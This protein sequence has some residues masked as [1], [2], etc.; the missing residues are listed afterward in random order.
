M[1]DTAIKG[2]QTEAVAPKQPEPEPEEDNISL[3]PDSTEQTPVGEELTEGDTIVAGEG[4]NVLGETDLDEYKISDDTMSETKGTTGEASLEEIEESVNLDTFGSGSGLLDLSLQ[5]DDTSLGGILDEIYT[6]EGE[7]EAPA[8]EG[9]AMDVA[10][11]ADQ[12]LSDQGLPEPGPGLEAG[13]MVQTVA[14]APPDAL[15]N[16][17][18][19]MLF[20]PLLLIIYTAIVAIAGFK[21]ITPVILQKIQRMTGPGDV[22]IIWYIMAGFAVAAAVILGV[23]FMSSG[24]KSAKKTKE[25]KP[26]AKKPK[27]KKEKKAKS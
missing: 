9:S 16:A 18:G 7:Q 12:M 1:A 26:K 22:Q 13:P 19:I 2:A 11:E 23:G 3:A 25:K 20:L 6:P 15:S 24:D 17:L 10:A 14:E 21:G 5:A 4:I 27:K 8:V